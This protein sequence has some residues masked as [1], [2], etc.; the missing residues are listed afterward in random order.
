M[1]IDLIGYFV[2]NID[3]CLTVFIDSTTKLAKNSG[4]ALINFD[5]I[6]VFAQL[7]KAYSPML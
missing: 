5:D 7:S 6:D 4:S 3:Y 1:L 2:P